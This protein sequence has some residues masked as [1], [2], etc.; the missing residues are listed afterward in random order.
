ME[1]AKNGPVADHA[2]YIGSFSRGCAPRGY[3]IEE[4]LSEGLMPMAGR[5]RKLAFASDHSKGSE[6]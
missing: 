2:G 5:G 3:V 6:R 1:L 4:G